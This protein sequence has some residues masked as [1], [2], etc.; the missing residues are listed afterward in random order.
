MVSWAGL[1]K[2]ICNDDGSLREGDS[3]KTAGLILRHRQDMAT[4]S[5]QLCCGEEVVFNALRSIS[6]FNSTV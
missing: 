2:C 1:L 6:E 4:V 3:Q 5:V